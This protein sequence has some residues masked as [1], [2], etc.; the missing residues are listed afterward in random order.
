MNG[1]KDT[2]V[3]EATEAT[4][5]IKMERVALMRKT[6][7]KLTKKK[8]RTVRDGLCFSVMLEEAES[9]QLSS[10]QTQSNSVEWGRS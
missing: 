7:G 6:F 10:K 3:T 8:Q 9:L 2:K 4:W 5:N 1:V